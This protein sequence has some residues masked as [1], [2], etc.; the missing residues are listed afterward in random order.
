MCIPMI[1]KRLRQSLAIFQ[2]IKSPGQK[3]PIDIDVLMAPIC[4]SKL[5]GR[6]FTM[7]LENQKKFSLT[8]GI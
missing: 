5:W 8:Q 3:P 6:L 4:G 1:C 2:L 7:R